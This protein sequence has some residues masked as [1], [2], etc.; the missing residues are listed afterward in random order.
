MSD[1]WTDRLSEYLDGE[2]PMPASGAGSRRT[3]E[4]AP[5]APPRWPT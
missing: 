3:C 1:P 5:S 4:S 2:L